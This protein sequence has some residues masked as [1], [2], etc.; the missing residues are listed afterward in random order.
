MVGQDDPVGRVLSAE[1]PRLGFSV[2]YE[3]VDGAFVA[4]T[5][6]SDFG[7]SSLELSLVVETSGRVLWSARIMREWDMYASSIE[8]YEQNTRKALQLLERDLARVG[9]TAP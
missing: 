8:A 5:R 9:F 2:E 6:R 4:V 7:P 3:D 1:L